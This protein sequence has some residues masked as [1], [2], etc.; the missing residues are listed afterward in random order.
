MQNNIN[1]PKLK[2]T[3]D[4]IKINEN[5][6]ISIS[7]YEKRNTTYYDIIFNNN[8]KE[9]FIGRYIK[10]F[11]P[12]KAMY[13]EGK[14]LVYTDKYIQDKQQS[15]ITNIYTLYDILDDVHY[16]ETEEEMLKIFNPN[17][18]DEYLMNKNKI[19]QRSDIE[20]KILIKKDKIK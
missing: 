19:V 2:Y 1:T 11:E 4:I 13:N 17:L 18:S 3:P 15:Y 14:I 16:N 7:E 12:I 20:K 10:E 8:G 6:F 5:N 9:I